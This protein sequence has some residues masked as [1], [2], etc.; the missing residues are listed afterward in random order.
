MFYVYMRFYTVGFRVKTV[1]KNMKKHGKVC[2]YA[3][4]IDKNRAVT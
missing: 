3:K 4:Y 1:Y 2:I